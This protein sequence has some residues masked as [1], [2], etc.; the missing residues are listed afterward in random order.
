MR[1]QKTTILLA[2]LL[3]LFLLPVGARQAKADQDG[4]WTYNVKDDT[5]SITGYT[6]SATDLVIPATVG[7]LKVTEVGDYAFDGNLTVSSVVFPETLTR[8]GYSAFRNCSSLTEVTFPETL[9]VID[10]SAFEASKVKNVTIPDSVTTIGCYA[11]QNCTG[12]RTLKLGSGITNWN[13]DW[14]VNGAFRNCTL[15]SDVAIAKGTSSIGAYAF[16]GC[17]LLLE[18]E[19]PETVTNVYEGAF[20]GCELLDTAIIFGSVGNYAFRNNTSM[21]DLYLENAVSIGDYAFENN[22]SLQEVELPETLNSLGLG[23]F[24]GCTKL[25]SITIPDTVTFVGAFCF[26]NCTQMETAI[27]G[28]SISEWGTDWSE[29]G[30][31]RNCTKLKSVTIKEGVTSLPAIIFNGCTLLDTLDIPGSVTTIGDRAFQNDVDLKTVILHD[32]LQNIGEYAFQNCTSLEKADLPGTLLS[33][34]RNAFENTVLREAI[35]PDKVNFIGCFAFANC[36]AIEKVYLGESVESWS[37]DWGENGAFMNDTRLT[38]VEIADGVLSIGSLAFQN[39]GVREVEIPITVTEIGNSAFRDCRSL[40]RVTVQ[41]GVIGEGVFSGCEA[42]SDVTL[43]R[44]TSINN[45]AFENCISLSA[46]ELPDTITNIGNYAFYGCQ[47]L[48]E[49]V[50]PESV[51]TMGAYAFANCTGLLQAVIGNN[52]T[53]WNTDWGQNALFSGD[54]ALEYAILEDGA[55]SLGSRTFENCI[56]LK[57]VY[58]PDSVVDMAYGETF[59]GSSEGVV[60]YAGGSKIQS[61]IRDTCGV[62]STIGTFEMPSRESFIITVNASGNGT[63]SPAGSVEKWAGSKQLFVPIPDRGYMVESF[64]VNGTDCYDPIG[65]LE[66]ISGNGEVN[67]T[68]AADPNYVDEYPPL[69]GQEEPVMPETEPA[70]TEPAMPET[71]PAETEPAMPETEPAETEPAMPETEPAETEPAVADNG[72]VRYTSDDDGYNMT[73]M[74]ISGV[75]SGASP[76]FLNE[77]SNFSMG[78]MLNLLYRLEGAPAVEWAKVVSDTM[79]AGAWYGDAAA[80]AFANGILTDGEVVSITPENNIS[81]GEAALL[82]YRYARS[83]GI[84]VGPMNNDLSRYSDGSEPAGLVTADDIDLSWLFAWAM[85]NGLDFGTDGSAIDLWGD[86]LAGQASRLLASFLTGSLG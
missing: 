59:L 78:A 43:K 33:I 68:F 32:G 28:S 75:L 85:E 38:E 50:I 11:F 67:V 31:F 49:I 34:G 57:A 83:K 65:V 30:A 46:V 29:N 12:L 64:A 16:A 36:P 3:F 76:V 35:I 23:S 79:E 9:L 6:G 80:W 15:L 72:C 52:I 21:K 45:Y 82:I 40:W 69:E 10:N 60:I 8:I 53:T 13:T 62:E 86:A 70:E 14:G 24:S 51:T 1:Q 54:T 5:A 26:Q 73:N 19:L 47:S 7:G 27:L 66:G 39:T 77:N 74:Y 84:P 48:M 2:V 44:I 41:R 42:L 20:D 63:V 4:D 56:S 18:I 55:N 22:T 37:T 71:E 81:R 25:K 61:L 17:T 58:L